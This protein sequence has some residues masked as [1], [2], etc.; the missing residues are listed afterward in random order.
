M[1]NYPNKPYTGQIM[2][3]IWYSAKQTICQ[4]SHS[5]LRLNWDLM[6]LAVGFTANIENYYHK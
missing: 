4:K 2:Y 1:F 3:H 5:F 6:C